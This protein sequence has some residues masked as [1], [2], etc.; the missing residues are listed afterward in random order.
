MGLSPSLQQRKNALSILLPK[1]LRRAS[2][3]FVPEDEANLPKLAH[4]IL[5]TLRCRI[6]D[7]E[8]TLFMANIKK[9]NQSLKCTIPVANRRAGLAQVLSDDPERSTPSPRLYVTRFAQDITG[10]LKCPFTR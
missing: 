4:G 10:H 2:E 6:Y 5:A 9:Q 1:P 8:A 7:D 3:R